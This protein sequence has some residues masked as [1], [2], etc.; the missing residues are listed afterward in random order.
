MCECV[1][2]C[3]YVPLNNEDLVGLILKPVLRRGT[4]VLQVSHGIVL[5]AKLHYHSWRDGVGSTV[6]PNQVLDAE[7]NTCDVSMVQIRQMPE[8]KIV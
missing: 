8:S 2:A 7:L 6:F 3:V 4:H 1:H 5:P